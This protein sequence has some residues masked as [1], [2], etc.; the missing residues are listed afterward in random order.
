[1]KRFVLMAAAS[2]ALAAV[3]AAQNAQY[4]TLILTDRHG[5]VVRRLSV[6]PHAWSNFGLP[7]HSLRFQF[8]A[9][10]IP[11]NPREEPGRFYIDPPHGGSMFKIHP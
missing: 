4:R 7:S 8:K 10:P 11:I 6:V 1:M 2:A 5:K 9:K 3:C